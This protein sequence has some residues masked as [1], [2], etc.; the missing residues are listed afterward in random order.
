MLLLNSILLYDCFSVHEY[1]DYF[2]IC[3]M[4][5]TVLSVFV[6][7]YVFFLL[8]KFFRVVSLCLFKRWPDSFP[9]WCEVPPLHA[10]ASCWCFLCYYSQL[11]VWCTFGST[12]INIPQST[13]LTGVFADLHWS[14]SSLLESARITVSVRIPLGCFHSDTAECTLLAFGGF[15]LPLLLDAGWYTNPVPWVEVSVLPVMLLLPND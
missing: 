4:N 1:L 11:S 7:I 13:A 9:K 3:I 12:R 2:H 15:T 10:F 8:E 5:N 14:D 6:W